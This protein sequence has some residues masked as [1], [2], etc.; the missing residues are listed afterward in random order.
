MCQTP[1]CAGRG[2]DSARGVKPMRHSNACVIKYFITKK[3][4]IMKNNP[5]AERERGYRP[6]TAFYAIRKT[7]FKSC[8]HWS[9][10]MY[11]D[12]STNRA[13]QMCRTGHVIKYSSTYPTMKSSN[14]G[15]V[16]GNTYHASPLIIISNRTSFHRHTVRPMLHCLLKIR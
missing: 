3:Q 6:G 15:W 10:C 14:P 5:R 11:R 4:K 7:E 16:L 12:P 9:Q 13:V 8:N 1:V 2:F